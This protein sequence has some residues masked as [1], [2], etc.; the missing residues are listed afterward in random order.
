MVFRL[1]DSANLK[2][3]KSPNAR[4]AK[5]ALSFLLFLSLASLA[6][7]SASSARVAGFLAIG[8]SEYINMRNILE[9]LISR[10]H[11]V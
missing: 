11:E 6:V 9:E 5:M 3:E 7:N 10:S 4:K 1:R 8:G 2:S